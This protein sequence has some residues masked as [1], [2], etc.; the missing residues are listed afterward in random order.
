MKT[1]APKEKGNLENEE[2]EPFSLREAAEL[3]NNNITHSVQTKAVSIRQKA[4]TFVL[5][6]KVM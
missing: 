3:I 1:E 4:V 5:E 2:W 6:V